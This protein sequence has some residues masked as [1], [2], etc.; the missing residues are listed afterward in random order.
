[1]L[2]YLERLLRP[3]IVWWFKQLKNINYQWLPSPVM[4]SIVL[5]ISLFL[6]KDFGLMGG[7]SSVILLWNFYHHPWYETKFTYFTKP[8]NNYRWV[9]PFILVVGSYLIPNLPFKHAY[10]SL[11][12]T[13]ITF[14]LT[15]TPIIEELIFR[16]YIYIS[17]Q[18]YTGK[19]V[20]TLTTS[21]LFTL[22]HYPETWMQALVYFSMGLLYTYIYET[23]HRDIRVPILTHMIY[24]TLAIM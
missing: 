13:E 3:P 14:L 17:L 9:I 23:S 8:I 5:Y 2:F 16:H 10:K 22:I 20:G 4:T 11:T 1:M 21:A 12:E 15:T 6:L 24:N 18:N 19:V 7:L